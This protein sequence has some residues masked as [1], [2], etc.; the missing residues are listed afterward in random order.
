M[1]E[2]PQFIPPMAARLVKE[3]PVGAEWLYEV[4]WDGY[5][6]EAIKSGDNVR[7][8]SRN[9]KDLTA[10]FPEICAAAGTIKADTA[11]LD[12]EVIAVDEQGKPSFQALQHRASLKGRITYYAFDLLHLNGENLRR[13]PLIDRRRKLERLLRGSGVL[14]SA[15]LDSELD[16]IA[17]AV[18]SAGLEGIVA[19]RRD[20]RYEPG[21]R[22]LAWLKVQ[23]KRQQEF[24]IGGYK[25]EAS[26]FGS[27]LVGYYD[28]KEL[29]F[30]GKVR[31]GFNRYVRDQLLKAMKPLE[32]V[33]NPF[34][35]LPITKSS[36]WGEGLTAEE[37]Q[38][39]KWL[40][41]RLVAQIRFTEWTRDGHLR[42]A[43]F[44]GLRADKKPR[45]V[46]RESPS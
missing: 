12:G 9:A 25:P 5:R 4:K 17:E 40:K 7:L 41:P 26:S 6:V 19:K 38:Q 37:M 45:E 29:T 8:I 21:E 46:V 10:T 22:S 33:A 32:T 16:I 28:G 13:L 20:S 30:A 15:E 39:V 31:G 44:L 18:K 36:R 24:V 27:I 11:V 23:F 2:K 42:H 1:P 3:L 43:D 35:N 14:F 34:P